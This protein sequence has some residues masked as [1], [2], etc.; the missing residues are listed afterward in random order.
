MSELVHEYRKKYP[1]I[2]P[3][4]IKE[5]S[6]GICVSNLAYRVG[7]RLGMTD[8]ECH[9]LAVAGI[10]HDIGKL[11]ISKYVR[12]HGE[13]TLII[14]ELKYVRRHSVLGANVLG[15][16]G[17]SDQIVDMVRYHHEN[18]DGSGYPENL[19]R[20]EIPLGARVLRVCD[21]FA[22]LT[23]DRPYR[24]AFD[25]DT[26]MELMIDESRYY[27][28]RVFLAF[29]QVV[30]EEELENVIDDGDM[31]RALRSLNWLDEE[32]EQS[33]EEPDGGKYEE[34]LGEPD[35]GRHEENFS[36][37]DSG[38]Y[39]ESLG[40]PDSGKYEENLEEPV[41]STL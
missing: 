30:H 16:M 29:M 41:E 28:I 3:S 19:V 6:H 11:E 1:I 35:G 14:E 31:E 22:A 39:E 37:L 13:E 2:R 36:K 40:G 33:L 38:K 20:E 34:S 25:V 24:K 21:V 12:G 8:E 4:V 7:R 10:L 17:Y 5:L 9:D 27:D 32:L 23:A 26:A 18:C 15:R